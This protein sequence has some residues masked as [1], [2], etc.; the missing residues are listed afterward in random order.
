[1]KDEATATITSSVFDHNDAI[2]GDGDMAG[3]GDVLVG[4]GQGGAIN[5]GTVGFP[6]TPTASN[7]T[8]TNNRAIGGNGDAGSV[9]FVGAG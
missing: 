6:A 4:I 1:M 9:A 7:L 5:N 8:M 2:G 3:S